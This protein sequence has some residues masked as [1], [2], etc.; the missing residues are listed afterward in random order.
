MTSKE[1]EKELTM[2]TGGLIYLEAGSGQLED[3]LCLVS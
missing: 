1:K 2:K 3:S